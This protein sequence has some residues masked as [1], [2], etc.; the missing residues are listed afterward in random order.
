MAGE[1]DCGLAGFAAA[2]TYEAIPE[3][4]REDIARTCCWTR[5]PARW[6][7]I[8]AGDP[9]ASGAAAGSRSPTKHGDRRRPHRSPARPAQRLS[10][11]RRHHVRRPPVHADAHHAGSG[12]AGAGDRERD[13]C[14]AGPAGRARGRLQVTTRI[15]GSI[16]RPFAPAGLAGHGAHL[17]SVRGGGV[18]RLRFDAETMARV[19]SR[20][21]QA[22]GTFAAWERRRWNS[23]SAGAGCRGRWRRTWPS[24]NSSRRASS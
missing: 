14:Q 6:R 16:S 17:R 7:R 12:C 3:R 21:R 10:H 5:S 20:R 1:A 22:A 23:T 24:R 11:H 4:V 18:G 15:V 8:R 2:L 19:R 13:G 9:S